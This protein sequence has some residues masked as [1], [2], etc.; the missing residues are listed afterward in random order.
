MRVLPEDVAK[1]L[2]E[3]FSQELKE[4]AKFNLVDN[5][6]EPSQVLVQL[7]QDLH[8]IDP[9]IQYE[10]SRFPESHRKEF[11]KVKITDEKSLFGYYRDNWGYLGIPSNEEFRTLIEDIVQV[12]KRDPGLPE[13]VAQEVKQKVARI[14]EPTSI[15]VYITLQCPYCP[16]MVF[17]SHQLSMLNPK[18]VSYAIAA[19]FYP[20]SADAFGVM[21]VPRIIVFQGDEVVADLLGAMPIN[22]YVD[23]LLESIEKHRKQ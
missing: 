22:M 10:L 13:E 7:F 21:E 20:D 6:S 2:K 23:K 12:S 3:Y 5:G 11:A 18:I 14:Q 8:D 15:F 19:E 16:Y 17:Y 4:P 1:E 9:R